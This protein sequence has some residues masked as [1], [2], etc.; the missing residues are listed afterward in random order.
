MRVFCK[1]FCLD[2]H[3]S[4]LTN[5]QRDLRTYGTDIRIGK[6]GDSSTNWNIIVG[7]IKIRRVDLSKLSWECHFLVSLDKKL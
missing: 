2:L 1:G 5:L 7:H 3:E 4:K 6:D